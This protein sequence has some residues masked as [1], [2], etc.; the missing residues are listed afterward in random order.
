[1]NLRRS[2]LM[3]MVA[4]GGA[5]AICSALILH[6]EKGTWPESWPKELEPLRGRAKTVQ[7]AHGIQETVYEIPFVS[8]EEFEKAWPHILTL[9]SKGAPIILEQS[10][11]TYSRSGSTMST[12]VRILWPSGGTVTVT[13]GTRLEAKAPWP[14]SARTVGG[15]LAE[16]VVI[17]NGKWVPFAGGEP[18]GFLNRARVDI[19]L[20]IDGKVIDPNRI[21]FPKGTPL[22]DQRPKDE[23]KGVSLS[24]PPLK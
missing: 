13:N 7:V 3:V 11:S 10:P 18:R 2:I 21:E 9:K 16:Y 8:R 17:E 22:V 6:E 5:S 23:Q 4:V 19:M 24:R 12:G 1:M 15:E 20:V 14:E